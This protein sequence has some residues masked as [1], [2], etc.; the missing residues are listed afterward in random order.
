MTGDGKHTAYKNGDDWGMLYEIGLPTWYRFHFENREKSTPHSANQL[1]NVD[2][3]QFTNLEKNGLAMPAHFG[4]VPLTSLA[5]RT[6]DL[7]I[8]KELRQ[9]HRRLPVEEKIAKVP[10]AD[11]PIIHLREAKVGQ[12]W[13]LSTA[14]EANR[15]EFSSHMLPSG[16]LT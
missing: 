15:R 12:V 10:P 9:T 16:K 13:D 4:I 5:I 3:L 7:V 1:D 2:K 8:I 6:R 14:N 11:G